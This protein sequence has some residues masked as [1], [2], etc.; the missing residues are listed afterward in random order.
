MITVKTVLLTYTALTYGQTIFYGLS[1]IYNTI[2]FVYTG[3]IGIFKKKDLL[4]DS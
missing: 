2:K 4:A 3:T 1:G